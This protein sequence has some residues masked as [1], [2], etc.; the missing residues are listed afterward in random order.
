MKKTKKL[1]M[2]LGALS[3]FGAAST[4]FAS[5][6]D[7]PV[8]SSPL[9]QKAATQQA[10]QA[11]RDTLGGQFTH[12]ALQNAIASLKES[13]SE[14]SLSVMSSAISQLGLGNDAMVE[15]TKAL[16]ESFGVTTEAAASSLVAE[17]LLVSSQESAQSLSQ[18]LETSLNIGVNE[19]H[20]DT[21]VLNI[22]ND[23][24]NANQNLISG[25]SS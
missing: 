9:N 12:S 1:L 24:F 18:S 10:V 3:L 20:V 2:S 7:T 11:L 5:G 25:F 21:T 15:A 6:V 8:L 19:N 13:N 14:I 17:T 4:V 16:S 22:N 23:D